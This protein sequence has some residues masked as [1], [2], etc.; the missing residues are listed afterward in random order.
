M[1]V[2]TLTI[3]VLL[4]S[5]PLI[6]A[7]SNSTKE[8][9]CE[10]QLSSLLVKYNK[11]VELFHDGAHCSTIT[12]MLKDF[13]KFLVEQRDNC[14]NELYQTKEEIGE[15]KAYRIGFYILLVLLFFVSLFLIF[16]KRKKWEK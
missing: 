12:Y 16:G 2:A 14:T 15:I 10:E 5:F 8:D 9:I 13:N 1:K 11:L 6:I 3:I 7:E 4:L